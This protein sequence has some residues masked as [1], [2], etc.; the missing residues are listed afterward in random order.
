MSDKKRIA[1]LGGGMA[2]L[3]TAYE[4][5]KLLDNG[6]RRYDIT[7][8]QQ[9]W[10]LGGKG[11]SGRNAS[12]GDRIEEHGL[13]VL[14]GCYENTFRILREIYDHE[15]PEVL[16]GLNER[17][18]HEGKRA[19][20]RLTR[21]EAFHGHDSITMYERLGAEWSGEPW[22]VDAPERRGQAGDGEGTRL[23]AANV[24]RLFLEWTQHWIEGWAAAH[25]GARLHPP[26]GL[27]RLLRWVEDLLG[28]DAEADRAAPSE[29]VRVAGI[30]EEEAERDESL[31]D[32]LERW[33]ATA[34]LDLMRRFTDAMAGL[35]GRAAHLLRRRA[36]VTDVRRLRVGADFSLIVLRGLLQDGVVGQQPDWF[37]I[38]NWDLRAWLRHHGAEPATVDSAIVDG[39]YMA[40]FSSKHPLAAG[41]ILHALFRAAHY[42]GHLFYRMQGGMGDIIFAPLYLVLENRGVTFRFFHR[43]ERIDARG[44]R[45][46]KVVIE[47]QAPNSRGYNPLVEV[48][49]TGQ[50][51]NLLCWPDRLIVDRL[52]PGDHARLGESDPENWW[53]RSPTGTSVELKARSAG[54]VGA[55]NEHEFDVLVLGISVGA[56]GEICDPIMRASSRFSVMVGSVVTTP[57]QAA[58]LW[59]D[60][61]RSS[62]GWVYPGRAQPMVIPFEGDF[63]T[64]ADMSHL[65]AWENV[66]AAKTLVYVCSS[67]RED[68][69]PPPAP[70]VQYTAD[71]RQC[72]L[73][74]LRS[75]L[76]GPARKLWPGAG[77]GG[78]LG[79]GSLVWGKLARQHYVAVI[80]PSDR[81]VLA[82]PGSNQFRLRADESGFENLY[83]T[84]DWTKTALSIG[85]LEAATMSGIQTARAVD[86]QVP[87]ASF[88]WLP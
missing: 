31:R 29:Y 38:D 71:L 13:H 14:F 87:K 46:E 61:D 60:K 15:L 24:I 75:W 10:R 49:I 28:K 5:S 34:A 43:V 33:A 88:D 4:L 18:E 26:Q 69:A 11:A 74:N 35:S 55:G 59:L 83:L 23:G 3:V 54:A 16:K 77:R 84:G 25:E 40:S 68:V 42:K 79:A 52:D 44:N 47:N 9:G 1:I 73:A 7:V 36:V 64:C 67:L 22:I 21:D 48:G 2:S 6:E 30:L 85:C 17:R 72:V 80:H 63:D 41:T 78:K 65:L 19:V 86:S 66:P 12:M 8:Y 70:N 39:L 51:K 32:W 56:L 50:S 58:Q 62:L 57:T 53:D 37:S 27:E 20:D 82:V 81:Y 45:I 76:T